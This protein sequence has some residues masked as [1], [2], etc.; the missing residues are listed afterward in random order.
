[1]RIVPGAALFLL[2]APAAPVLAQTPAELLACAVIARDAERLACFD[3][4]V[5]ASSAEARA[6]SQKRAV[7]SARIAAEEAA[8][9]AAA[10]KAKAEADAI[11][12]AE[13]K[14]AAFGAEGVTSRGVERFAPEPGDI[15]EIDAKVTEVLLNRSQQNVFLLDN[16]MMWRQV[17]AGSIPNVRPDDEVKLSK[18]ALGGYKLY[19][20]RS[21]RMVKVK[22]LR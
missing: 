17:D 13:A 12:L 19:F 22:R 14:K 5:A 16:G 15:Q 11:A 1:M 18:V 6:A 2:L 20:V 4:A 21:K 9:A 10:A 3:A 8:I 7:E